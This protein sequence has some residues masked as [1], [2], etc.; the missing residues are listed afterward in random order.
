MHT[1]WQRC[2]AL[3]PQ[4]I[5]R[6]SFWDYVP[7]TTQ[8]KKNYHQ[9]FLV[10][11]A[12]GS[13]PAGQG[14]LDCDPGLGR[15]RAFLGQLP[16]QHTKPNATATEALSVGHAQQETRPVRALAP[17]LAR[18]PVP[19]DWSGGP[20]PQ[21]D[22]APPEMAQMGCFFNFCRITRSF[23]GKKERSIIVLESKP[24]GFNSKV[25][26][27]PSSL[28]HD[29]LTHFGLFVLIYGWVMTPHPRIFI[30]IK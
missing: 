9:D 22:P 28:T 21:P 16:R 30:T 29:I 19:H 7:L 18:A 11:S 8:D 10:V 3:S 24:S 1:H 5:S 27:Y 13:L 25:P 26:I 12:V 15:S 20:S 2:S 23:K 17:K 4:T 14:T 6:D